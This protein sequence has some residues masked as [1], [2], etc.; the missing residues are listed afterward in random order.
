MLIL[1][2]AFMTLFSALALAAPANDPVT[3]IC[4]WVGGIPKLYTEYHD[5]ACPP[6]HR[7]KANGECDGWDHWR[8]DCASFCE[9]RTTFAYGPE[10]PFLRAPS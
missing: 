6:K 2:G 7:I 4:A 9:V 3:N 1:V 10:Q 8:D 5:D